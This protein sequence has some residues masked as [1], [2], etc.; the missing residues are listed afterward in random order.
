MYLSMYVCIYT[1]IFYPPPPAYQLGVVDF[2]TGMEG[3]N[4]P[5]IRS[6]K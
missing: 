2:I 4:A 1:H 3:A 6:R 5:N